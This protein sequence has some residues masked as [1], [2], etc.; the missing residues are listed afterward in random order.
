[1]QTSNTLD[2]Q[3]LMG[4]CPGSLPTHAISLSWNT[5]FQDASSILVKITEY[6]LQPKHIRVTICVWVF[7]EG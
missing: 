4:H 6:P 1:M 2:K 7:S 5:S 3:F